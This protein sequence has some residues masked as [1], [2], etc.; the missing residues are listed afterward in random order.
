VGDIDDDGWPDL[1]IANDGV[2]NFLYHNQRNGSFVD[3]AYGAGV[4]FDGNGRPQAG[5]GTEIADYD[6]DGQ[7]DIF[8]TN[9]SDEL[10]TLYRNLGNLLFEDVTEKAGLGSG[11]IPLGFG[12]RFFDFDNDGDLD[13]HV[14]NGHVTD[15]VSLYHPHLAYAQRDQLYEN[16]GGKFRDISAA[17]GQ[18]FTLEH[19]GRGSAVADFDNDGDL[20][21]VISNLG[22]RPFLFR[23]DTAPQGQW[24]SLDLGRPDARVR[25]TAAGRTQLRYATSVNSYLSSSDPRLH[26]G[27]GA[28][29]EAARIEILWPGGAQQ[30][31]ENV[32]GGRVLK[33][34]GAAAPPGEKEKS[35]ARAQTPPSPRPHSPSR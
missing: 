5:M 22:A 15:N 30:V 27:L 11:L 25:L 20:D 29:S 16:T 28:A 34:R 9:F 7:P 6:G 24:L 13:I 35:Q 3:I 31:M 19:V 2:R 32:K 8:V 18:A 17:A 14:T 26:F 4:G 10:N 12:T 33:V 1:Y 23:N 21:I